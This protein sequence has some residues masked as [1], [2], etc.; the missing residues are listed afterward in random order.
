MIALWAF[1]GKAAWDMMEKYGIID[2]TKEAAGNAGKTIK[3]ATESESPSTDADPKWNKNKP[4]KKPEEKSELTPTQL[5]ATKRL[6]SDN[7]ITALFS[8]NREK[9]TATKDQYISFIN[10]ELKDKPVSVFLNPKDPKHSISS[11]ISTLDPSIILP[12]GMDPAILKYMLRVY[13]LWLS[14]R[15]SEL[16]KADAQIK[17]VVNK[18]D[19]SKDTLLTATQKTYNITE[20]VKEDIPKKIQNYHIVMNWAILPKDNLKFQVDEATE[21]GYVVSLSIID[22]KQL[23][24]EITPDSIEPFQ[25][26][27]DVDGKLETTSLKIKAKVWPLKP[28]KS[29]KLAQNGNQILIQ[30]A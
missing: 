10:K 2:K 24:M 29:Y 21:G 20:T 1:G 17:W 8:Q 22:P 4:I 27:F 6:N 14:L 18:F 3:W 23:K 13:I 7:H 15:P 16:V 26:D 25:V 11:I 28:S 19:T 5:E 9:F 12:A 30:E